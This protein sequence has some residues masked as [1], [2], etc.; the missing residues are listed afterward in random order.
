MQNRAPRDEDWDS[1]IKYSERIQ[2]IT[3]DEVANNVAASIFPILDEYR[4][5]LYILPRL[6]ELTW[7]VETPEG[8]ERCTTFLNPTLQ[9]INLEVGAKFPKLDDFL[10]DMLSRVNLKGFS[11]MSSTALPDAFTELVLHQND[12][13]K[14]VLVAPGALAPGVGRWAAS[15]PEL[16]YLQLDLTGR[17]PIAVEGFFDELRPRSGDSTPSSIGSRDS[18]VFSGEELDFTGIRKAALRLTGDLRSKGSF[19]SLK[20]LQ[21]TGEVANVAVFIKHLESDLTNL[22]LVIEDPPDNADWQDLSE[23]ICDRFADSLLSLR[24]TATP[25]SKFADLVRSTSRA[26]PPL[27]RLS[28]E[29]LAGLNKLARL[30]VDLPESV[31]FLPSDIQ[32]LA[33]ACPNVE[34]VRLCPLARFPLPHSPKITLESLV[35]LT[36]GCKRLHTLATVINACGGSE[37]V[38]RSQ[39]ASSKSL[40]R[41]HLGHS[42]ANDPLQIAIFLSHMA[43]GLELLKWFQERNRPGFNEI[44]AKNWQSVSEILPHLQQLR[45]IERSFIEVVVLEPEKP[46]I[47][48]KEIDATVSTTSVGVLAQMQTQEEGIQVSPVLESRGI[49]TFNETAEASVDA[50]PPESSANIEARPKSVTA[51]I[52]HAHQNGSGN[53]FYNYEHSRI[54]HFKPAVYFLSSLLGLFS[55]VY[56]C[57]TFP[58]TISSRILQLVL[59]NIKIES[60]RAEATV[61]PPKSFSGDPD[62]DS[63]PQISIPLDTLP[64]RL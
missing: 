29:K 31:I 50:T 14:V 57:S 5:M 25:S 53:P 48:D 19:S 27:A 38:L 33:R 44:H 10:A 26:E 21:L 34:V 32:N 6:Q 17:A 51:A 16:K 3:Y 40:H 41:L 7:K 64:V 56:R 8:L 28:L 59:S 49:E 18:G 42:W 15:L 2:K 4:P 24:I 30:D 12:L 37:K 35:P 52:M 36:S 11:F 9:Y 54:R 45:A 23:L 62:F 39:D 55:F 1:I 58:F 46:E 22:D 47:S 63:P 61:E 20:K 13:E 60:R 43:P